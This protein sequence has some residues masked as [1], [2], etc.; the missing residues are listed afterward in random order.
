MDSDT[1]NELRRVTTFGNFH[2]INAETSSIAYEKALKIGKLSNYK[3]ANSDQVEMKSSFLGIGDIVP[4][5]ED[6]EDGAEI[7]WTDYGFISDK[8]SKKMV[9]T[10]KELLSRI[11]P[12][13]K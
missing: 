7:L 1:S 13:A 12:K 3:F 2:L 8:R 10:K 9:R 6:I 5:Y 4:I 11:K